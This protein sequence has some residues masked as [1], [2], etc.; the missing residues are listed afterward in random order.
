M[1]SKKE[2]LIENQRLNFENTDLKDQLNY[3]RRMIFSKKS[4]RFVPA[5][6]GQLD[7]FNTDLANQQSEQAQEIQ[8][9][10]IEKHSRKKTK[11]KGRSLIAGLSHLPVIEVVID[12]AHDNEAIC[13]GQIE[14][15]TLGYTPA[16]F[17]INKEIIKKYKDPIKG[18]ISSATLPAQPIGSCEA[19]I[20]LLVYICVAKFVDHLPEYR[21][22]QIFKR[23]KVLIA[24]STMNG[25]VH[26][27]ADLL[28]PMS[29]LI[30]KKI[31][32]STYAM[33]DES[34]IKV[35]RSKKDKSHT[36]WMW[37]LYSPAMRCVQFVY[38]QGRD[39]DNAVKLLDDYTGKLQTD[40]YK[41]YDKIDLLNDDLDHS[42]C[43]AHARRYFDKA[44]VNDKPRAEY[45]M[46]VYQNLYKLERQ[47]TEYKQRH[48]DMSL[49]QY[50]AY[51]TDQRLKLIPEI[52]NY[53]D[54]L[55]KESPKVLPKSLIG[56]AMFYV[57]NRWP[58][59]TKYIYDGELEID[60]NL[61][62][63]TIRGLALG[64]KNYLFAGSPRAASN[65][66]VFY[67]IFGTCKHLGINP[68]EYLYWYLENVASTNINNIQS[69][70]PWEFIK[71]NQNPH[72]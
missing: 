44:L 45:A 36:G 35:L 33:A 56:K 43:N 29:D 4:E 25:W 7:I 9:V 67:S 2:L 48:E 42:H 28:R 53:K 72:L 16:E 30:G 11:H 58:K 8:E 68:Q 3:L 1:V 24:P 19:H 71:K 10:I 59:L 55:D 64:R 40:G 38:F 31:L 41:A 50:Y 54:W 37:V 27:C 18:T 23:D 63:N 47:L 46:R 21:Q 34:S 15:C 62:E 32:A 13:I 12:I 14:R 57:I 6:N 52:E 66:A 60:T 20:S 51:R 49:E 22:Q 5:L 69:L 26:N 65:I 17:Y 39:H 70:S 61:I